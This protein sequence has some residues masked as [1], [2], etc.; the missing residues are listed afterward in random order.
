MADGAKDTIIYIDRNSLYV[1][2]GDKILRADFPQNV[3]KD[4]EIIDKSGFDEV[5]EKFIMVNK[6]FPEKVW[7]ILSE[8]V[9]FIKEF[10]VQDETK[11]E[12]EIKY[13]LDAVPFDQIISKKYKSAQG[14]TVIAA[15]MNFTEG[16]RDIFERKGFNVM[17]ITPA[18]I[19]P[20]P[21]GKRVFDEGFVKIILG[22]GQIAESGN[23]IQKVS[24]EPSQAIRVENGS[25]QKKSKMLPYLIGVFALLLVILVV[26]L[27]LR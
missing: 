7:I 10:N 14:L 4:L 16:V 13:F 12:E 17:G 24:T 18:L 11:L 2:T 27:V 5:L 8:G 22:N 20:S 21:N 19:F 3:V 23:M 15:N 26:A 6:L 1:Y 25:P 9:C